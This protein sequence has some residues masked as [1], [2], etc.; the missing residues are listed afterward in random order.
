MPLIIHIDGGARGNPGPA[1]AGVVIADENGATLHESAHFLG[2]QTNNAAE[3]LALIHAL[4]RAADMPAQQVRIHSDSELLVK[5]ITGEYRV[6]SPSLERLYEQAQLLLLRFANWSIRHVR[7]EQNKRADEL[8]NI[9]MDRGAS[10]VICDT[11]RPTNSADADQDAEPAPDACDGAPGSADPSRRIHVKCKRA[12]KAGGCPN[13][14]AGPTDYDVAAS[15][16]AGVCIYAAHG[17][18]PTLVALR[19]TAEDEF[20]GAPAMTVLCTREACGAVFEVGPKRGS[21]GRAK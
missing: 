18:A 4:R 1:G 12:A 20:E 11:S 16:P 15:L 2:T 21:N 6:K 14:G 7:R 3:Y 17:L 10:A 19:G 5:Q 9:A 13:G 8:A